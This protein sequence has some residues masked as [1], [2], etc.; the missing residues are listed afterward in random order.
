MITI[1]FSDIDWINVDGQII[2]MSLENEFNTQARLTHNYLAPIITE[3]TWNGKSFP[4]QINLW[5]SYLMEIAVK[6][7]SIAMLAK[8]QSCSYIE[9]TDSM[10]NETIIADTKASGGISIE[11]VDRFQT[12]NQSFNFIVRTKKVSLYPGIAKNNVN[13][14]RILISPSFYDF[15]TDADI[16]SFV[17]DAAKNDYDNSNGIATTA[18]SIVKRGSKMV[19]YLMETAA[20]SLKEK[21]ENIGYTSATINPATLNKTVIE[22]GKCSLTLLTEGLYKCECELITSSKVAYA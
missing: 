8:I 5:E 21:I 13:L 10:T 20:I 3:D 9:I 16:I 7:L 17:S 18:K 19:F 6:E 1:K 11:M 22:Q 4:V 14:L 15:Y 2:K 12:T